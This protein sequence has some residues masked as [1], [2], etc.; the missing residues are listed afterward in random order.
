MWT[1]RDKGNDVNWL[2]ASEYAKKFSLAGY[3]DWRL[4]TI[5]ELEKLHDPKDGNRFNIRKPFRLTGWWVWSSTREGSDSAWG[6]NFLGGRRSHFR[7]AYPFGVLC[8]RRSGE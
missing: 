6:F 4:A 1:R 2:E 7:M 3:S 8:V 5:E